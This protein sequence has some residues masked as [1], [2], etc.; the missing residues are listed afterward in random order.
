MVLLSV[1]VLWA[2]SVDDEN[3]F[4][5]KISLSIIVNDI[6]SANRAVLSIIEQYGLEIDAMNIDNQRRSS[7]F[8]LLKQGGFGE[9]VIAA[10]EALG[11]T[12]VKE[13]ETSNNADSL[14]AAAYDLDFL[15]SRQKVYQA[16]LDNPDLKPSSEQYQHLW[17][18]LRAIEERIYNKGK[19]SIDLKKEV[20]YSTLMLSVAEKT[21]QYLNGADD[22]PQFI[23]MPGIESF[24]FIIENPES[25]QSADSY[26]GGAL[27]YMFTVG[28][29]Y[30]TV[31]ILKPLLG[32]DSSTASQAN[33]I[34]TYSIGKDFYPR[35]LGQGKRTFFN[36]YSGF[37]VGGMV[38]TSDE[39]ISHFFTAEP[40]VGVEIFKN[41][42]VIVDFRIGYL[43]PLDEQRVKT[44]RGLTN[45]LSV[46]I[47]F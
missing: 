37:Q 45:N 4:S 20:E 46:N 9:P 6:T 15:E 38:L 31:G 39:R 16:E 41:K 36:P 21:V 44:M 29:S 10:V 5:R 33:D 26:A 43:F 17:N 25:G 2:Q 3:H 47:V 12:D 28:K 8:V 34:V 19:E 30:F 42:Y 22:F 14:D 40:H 23:N 32:R 27:R 13:V 18:E 24:V 11:I 7:T 35:Y 1:S